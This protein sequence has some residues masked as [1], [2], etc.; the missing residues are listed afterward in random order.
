MRADNECPIDLCDLRIRINDDVEMEKPPIDEFDSWSSVIST[1]R[2]QQHASSSA[3]IVPTTN[4]SQRSSISTIDHIESSLSL[5][6]PD[7]LWTTNIMPLLHDDLID[8]AIETGSQSQMDFINFQPVTLPTSAYVSPEI[9][10]PCSPSASP[11]P[12]SL[13]PSRRRRRD[14]RPCE[15]LST[16]PEQH[17]LQYL[18]GVVVGSGGGGT[19]VK[20]HRLSNSSAAS[21]S[22]TTSRRRGS[23]DSGSEKIK[24]S[25]AQQKLPRHKRPSHIRAETK[26]RGKIQHELTLFKMVSW[27]A[28]RWM[29]SGGGWKRSSGFVLCPERVCCFSEN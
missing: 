5:P 18:T 3:A 22:T 28:W 25:T 4:C 9:S 17:Q 19:G 10:R 1:C 14:D 27:L 7:D 26:R 29:E 23:T 15:S 2:Q 13:S 11:S 16:S 12:S 8:D 21:T 24:D 20:Q 6:F